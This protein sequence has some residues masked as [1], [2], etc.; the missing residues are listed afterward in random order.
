MTTAM[1]QET[2]AILAIGIPAL[3]GMVHIV[4]KLGDIRA[5]LAVL[6]ERV[7]DHDEHIKAK[8]P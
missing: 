2:V 1:T 6:T 3:L 5:E 4:W 8:L 7:N